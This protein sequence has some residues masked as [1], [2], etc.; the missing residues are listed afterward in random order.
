MQINVRIAMAVLLFASCLGRP[1]EVRSQSHATCSLAPMKN[2]E[3]VSL[4]GKIVYGAHDLLLTIK[5]CDEAVVLRYAG[6]ADSAET[7][8]SLVQ[9][10]ALRKFQKYLASTYTRVGGGVCEQ[11][12]KY[13]VEATLT[14][15]IDIASDSF[16]QGQWKD[17]VGFLHDASGKV[18]GK[19]GFGH[20]P[21]YKYRLIIKSVSHVTARKLPKPTANDRPADP[22]ALQHESGHADPP[23]PR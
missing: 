14:G 4:N 10:E 11:C 12:P 2:G 7:R 1:L 23:K 5:G 22:S 21:S 20:P 3:P 16:P 9:D 15:R 13:E 19:A 6:D 17:K 8:D 18:V